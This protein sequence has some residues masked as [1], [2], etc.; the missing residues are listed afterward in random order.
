M[1][2]CKKCGAEIEEGVKFCPNCGEPVAEEVKAETE[3]PKTEET[4]ENGSEQNAFLKFLFG[5]KDTTADYDAKDIEDNK[6]MSILA[7]CGPLW[8]V[9]YFVNKESKYTR[10]HCSQAL[11]TFIGC[12]ASFVTGAVIMAILGGVPVV[13]WLLSV[14][15]DLVGLVSLGLIAVG[16]INVVKGKARELP[17][18]GKYAFLK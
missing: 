9:A 11:L 16:I 18:I 6:V 10:F 5:T 12:F 7:Y 8:F 14:L 4:K 15:F 1:A 3:A 2:T 13:G 17:I